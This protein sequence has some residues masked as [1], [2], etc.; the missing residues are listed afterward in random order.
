MIL[1]AISEYLLPNDDVSYSAA[2]TI[3]TANS[4]TFRMSKIDWVRFISG[5]VRTFC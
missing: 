3:T 4:F 1:T 5:V 2:S